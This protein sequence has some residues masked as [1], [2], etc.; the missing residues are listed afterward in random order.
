MKTLRNWNTNIKCNLFCY[1]R[2]RKE[3][4]NKPWIRNF[5]NEKL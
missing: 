1:P 4:K 5:L 3:I 2:K